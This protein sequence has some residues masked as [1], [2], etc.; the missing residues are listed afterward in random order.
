MNKTFEEYFNE[1]NGKPFD[2]QGK[3][4]QLSFFMEIENESNFRLE[5]F[6]TNSDWKQGIVIRAINGN[7][8][9]D[10]IENS[11]FVFWED[12]FDEF[13]DFEFKYGEKLMIYNV[14]DTGNGQMQYGHN[15]AGIYI[16]KDD[17]KI[18]LNCNDGHPNADLNDLIFTLNITTT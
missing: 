14:W 10:R 6:E 13:I 17:Y 12:K 2:Y 4:I 15:G 18:T 9:F 5:N 8:K 3:T 11:A 7:L 16:K 1:S